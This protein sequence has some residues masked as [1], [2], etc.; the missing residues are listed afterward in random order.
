V[1]HPSLIPALLLA[2]SLS[3]P[4]DDRLHGA[5]R[6][7]ARDWAVDVVLFLVALALGVIFV[8]LAFSHPEPPPD[9]LVFFDLLAGSLGCVALWWRRRWPVAVALLLAAIGTFSDM[10]GPAVLIALFTVAVHRPTRTLM[11]VTAAHLASLAVYLTVRPVPPA[12]L[13]LLVGL[14]GVAVIALVVAW[15][16]FVRARRQLV[17][18]LR[19]QV[20][21][22][23]TEQRLRVGQARDQERTRIAREMHDVLAHRLSLLSMH[24][25]ALEFRPDAPAD[26]VARAAGVIRASARG[27]L[28][29]L[30]EVIGVLRDTNDSASDR[31]QPTLSDLRALVEESRQAGLRVHEEYRLPDPGSAPPI[32]GRTAYRVVQEGLTNV[33]KHAHGAAATVVVEGTPGR[34][35]A[36]EVRN[37]PPL[38]GPSAPL[39]SAGT[40]L[41]GLLERVGLAG[42]TLAY[43]W[44]PDGEF[45]LRAELPWPAARVP[46]GGM[47]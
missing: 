32:L 8:G 29:D 33:R 31:P 27:A 16:M 19:N 47:A 14:V 40:G 18:S 20:D 6:R 13:P 9:L 42:G 45:R 7:S 4:G 44:T 41:I 46:A 39:P 5:V 12:E 28:E 22:A 43:G 37:L 26:E 36:V 11:A 24:A 30:R 35:L 3:G 17:H 1:D 2:D 25:G 34:G 23:E 10:A 38:G 15:G 21:R